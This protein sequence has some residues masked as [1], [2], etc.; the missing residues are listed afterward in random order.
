MK[1]LIDNRE[2]QIIIKYITS[3]NNMAKQKIIIEVKTLEIGDYIFYDEINNKNIIIIERKSLNDLESSIKDGRYDEQSFRLTNSQTHNHNIIYLI[4]GN[5]INH[6]NQNFKPS[7]YS[8]LFSLSYFKGFS[9]FN[10]INNVES[11]EI[12][13]SFANKLSRETKKQGFYQDVSNNNLI[14][15]NYID[16]VKT[17]KKSNITETN[18]MDLMLMQIPGI[19]SQTAK[20]LTKEFSSFSLLIESLKNSPEKFNEIKLSSGRKI[21][22]NILESLKRFIE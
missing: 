5:I 14:E 4:E 1:L 2:P 3:L 6:R 20:A 15:N 18:I 9:I 12:I 21:N 10:S 13:Y 11:G 17:N 7:M 16:H 19:S 8:A 22:K